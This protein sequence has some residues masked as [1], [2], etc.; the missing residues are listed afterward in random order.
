MKNPRPLGQGVALMMR[1]ISL[2]FVVLLAALPALAS[3]T[4]HVPLPALEG[5]YYV[6]PGPPWV[7]QYG[8][9]VHFELTRIPLTVYDVSFRITGTFTVGSVY[10]ELTGIGSTTPQA[11]EYF[12]DIEDTAHAAG[13][14]A[15]AQSPAHDETFDYAASFQ[16]VVHTSEADWNFLKAGYGRVDMSANFIM[17]P[18]CTVLVWPEATIESAE[19]II[20]AD[21][22]VGVEKSTWGSIKSLYR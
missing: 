13:F 8:R 17:F 3:E 7:V 15:A 6:D 11:L 1:A 12:A 16:K 4:L 9:S 14:Y 22:Q 19:L 5:R 18:E 2:A 20:E 21:F 10:C